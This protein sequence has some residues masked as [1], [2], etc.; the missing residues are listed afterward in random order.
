MLRTHI[1]MHICIIHEVAMLVVRA[2]EAA[3]CRSRQSDD[4]GRLYLGIYI[5]MYMYI[6]VYILIF[7]RA[8]LSRN[9]K[10]V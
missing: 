7:I 5:C 4:S 8:V 10:Y 1:H 9:N 3:D 6:Y 2:I